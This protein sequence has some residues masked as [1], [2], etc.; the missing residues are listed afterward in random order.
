MCGKTRT[1]GRCS[2]G[3]SAS[4]HRPRRQEAGAAE[5]D[6]ADVQVFEEQVAQHGPCAGVARARLT[7]LLSMLPVE[8]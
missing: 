6:A 4:I 3:E 8:C 1:T 2:Q 7:M 5:H